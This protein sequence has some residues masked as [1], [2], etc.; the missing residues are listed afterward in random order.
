[1]RNLEQQRHCVA[2][3]KREPEVGRWVHVMCMVIRDELENPLASSDTLYD[4]PACYTRACY[5]QVAKGGHGAGIMNDS[6]AAAREKESGCLSL[7]LSETGSG[8]ISEASLTFD[9]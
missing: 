6:S 3:W 9:A 7:T 2:P 8:R 1:L 4:D 5:R